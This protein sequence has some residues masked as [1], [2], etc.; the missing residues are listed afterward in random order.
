MLEQHV[1]AHV[2]AVRN[3][4]FPN[5]CGAAVAGNSLEDARCVEDDDDLRELA[6]G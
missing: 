5:R 1:H 6:R 2:L 3:I 4:S